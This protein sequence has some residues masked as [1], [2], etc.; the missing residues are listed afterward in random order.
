MKTFLLLLS[1]ITLVFSES[2]VVWA[3]VVPVPKSIVPEKIE[4]AKPR[5]VVFILSDDHRYDAMSFMGHPFAKTPHMDAMAENG[6]HLKNAFVT[7]SL[8]SPSRASI[9]TGLYTFRHRVIDNQ[10][11]VPEGTIYFPQYLQAAGYKTGFIGKWHMG[12]ASDEPRPGFDY[13]FSFKGQGNYYPP[14]PNYTLNENGKRVPQDGYITPLLTRKAIEFLENQSN[15]SEPFFLYL[16]HK[17]VHGPFT[18]EPK[19]KDSLRDKTMELPASSELL[20]NN[21]K[22]RPRWLLDQRNSWHGMDFALHTGQSVEHFYKRYCE[23]LCSVDDSIGAVMQQLEKMGILDETLLIYMGDNG[24][25]FG[26]HGLFDKRVAY[27][28][29]SRVPMLM[30]CPEIAEGGTVVEEVVANIDIGPTVMEAMGLKTPPH[31]DGKS[32]LPLTQ[33]QS[34]PWRDYFLYVYYWEQN[35]P[36]TPTHFSLRGSQYKY[37]TY[38]GLWDTDELFD[39]Q[40]DPDEQNN[41]VHDPEFA[42]IKQQ[43]QDRLYEM[44]DELGGLQIP[45][46]PPRGNQQNKRLRSR[47]GVKAADFPEAFIVDEPLRSI[48]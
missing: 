6:V 7:T 10:R 37:T 31:M 4:G 8:C 23:A 38:Y 1:T 47:G 44:M 24:F 16:S 15:E 5:N 45:L 9:L 39:I 28:T 27:E 18:P 25:M 11:R 34:I 29:S 2:S 40:A 41:L 48:E 22:N 42:E 19:Y 14:G 36:Q 12:H 33:G 17:A 43:M 13:W 20:D 46:N 30:Q 26:E 32:F 21:L 35:Y 3:D